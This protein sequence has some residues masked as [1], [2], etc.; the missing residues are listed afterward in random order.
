MEQGQM[1]VKN[2][3]HS[4]N[5]GESGAVAGEFAL[6]LPVLMLCLF[7]IIQFGSILYLHT[8]ME[9][10][11]REAAR[12][13]AVNAAD[14]IQGRQVALDYLAGWGL[15]FN[16]NAVEAPPDVNGVIDVIV[17]ISVPMADAG[18]VRFIPLG[19]GDLQAEVRLR[20]ES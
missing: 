15:T 1:L 10:A 11:A 14:D 6:L 18:V 3:K 9:N 19:S 13:M 16:V 7:G 2:S 5:R 17:T 20:Q 4:E 12:R 8:N